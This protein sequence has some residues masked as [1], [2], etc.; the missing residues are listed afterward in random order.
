MSVAPAPHAASKSA[1]IKASWRILPL[2]GLGYLFS[3][4]DRL[5][6]SFAATQMNLDLGFS[7]TVY[8]LGGGFFFLTYAL[9][10]VPSGMIMPR[11]GARR[12]IARIMISWGLISAA[13]MFIRSPLQFYV[14]RLLLGAAEAGFWPTAIYFLSAWFP[15][16]HRGRALSRF[17]CFGGVASILMGVM[18]GWLLGLDGLAGLRGWQWLFLAEGLPAV[19]VGLAV[20][21]FLPDAPATA[22]WLT[23]PERDWITSELAAENAR[24]GAAADHHVLRALKDPM[25]LKLA[26]IGCLTI[27]SYVGFLLIAPQVLMTGTGLDASHV[28]YIVSGGGVLSVLGMLASGWHSDRL[29]QRFTHLLGSMMIVAVCF[30]VMALATTP[31]LMLTGYLA[32]AFFWPAVT[33]STCLV[34]TEVV[35]FRMVAVAM[36]AVN[37]L[38]QLGA[39]AVPALWGMSKDST[40]SFH[41]GMML[42]P[43]AFVVATGIGILLLSQ[44]RAK[45]LHTISVLAAA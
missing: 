40:G 8:G 11:F 28:G 13:M 41:L 32:L 36:A 44:V 30:L 42:V 4:L 23:E 19:F 45:K 17:Y 22:R 9:L 1:M 31:A 2:L 6:V 27:G 14:L 24:H 38:S 37:T 21:L 33:L 20:L 18:S 34:L 12:W 15:G 26:L 5:N 16:A 7:A 39:F 25:V 35:P 29:G 3:F 43:V 10:E